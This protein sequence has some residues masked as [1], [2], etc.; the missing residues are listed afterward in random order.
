VWLASKE[1]SLSLERD[2]VFI[3]GLYRAACFDRQTG[4]R[5]WERDLVGEW[6]L[7]GDRILLSDYRSWR[8]H[9]RLV[10][11]DAARGHERVIVDEPARLPGR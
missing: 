8:K 10:V 4:E 11:L 1:P 5:Q 2:L 3:K 9:A 7:L 6:K